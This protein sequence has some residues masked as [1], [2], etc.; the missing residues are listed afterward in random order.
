MTTSSSEL[1]D[2][3]EG[4]E[5]TP[6]GEGGKSGG[7]LEEISSVVTVPSMVTVSPTE[8]RILANAAE[9]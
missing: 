8:E 1:A 6:G 4:E 2:A 3:L 5:L 7:R 9:L